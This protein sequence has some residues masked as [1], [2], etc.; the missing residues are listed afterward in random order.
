[1]LD[2]GAL[3]YGDGYWAGQAIHIAAWCG[4]GLFFQHGGSVENTVI[5]EKAQSAT[6]ACRITRQVDGNVQI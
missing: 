5:T 2:A 3:G 4:F 6:S 1:M